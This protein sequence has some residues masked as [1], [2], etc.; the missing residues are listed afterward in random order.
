MFLKNHNLEVIEMKQ[1][2]DW[3][4]LHLATRN[5]HANIVEYLIEN[6]LADANA[7]DGN[8]KTSLHFACCS[9][10]YDI[11]QLLVKSSTQTSQ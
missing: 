4:G 10:H 11:V 8:G 7:A 5:G 9:G 6:G 1:N 3:T 2:D